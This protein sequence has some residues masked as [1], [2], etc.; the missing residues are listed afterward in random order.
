[1]GIGFLSSALVMSGAYIFVQDSEILG[2][3]CLAVGVF[4]G[5]VRFAYDVQQQ[6]RA[7][8]RREEL[9]E[10]SKGIVLN[11]IQAINDTNDTAKQTKKTIH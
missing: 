8:K 4:G 6:Q 1:M 7:E 2:G 5:I 9:F 3:I 11:V 10:I